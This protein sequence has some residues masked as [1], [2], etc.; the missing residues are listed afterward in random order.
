MDHS[1]TRTLR[2]FRP[3]LEALGDRVVPAGLIG[4]RVFQD[5]TGNGLTPDDAGLA[6]VT[7]RLFADTNRDGVRGAGDLL[8]GSR[9][10]G[11]DGAYAFADL[12]DGRYF[13][14]EAVPSGYVR[15]APALGS[16]A[17]V[18]VLNGASV[19]GQDFNN[20]QRP[21]TD[22]VTGVGYTITRG[23]SSFT[24]TN[25]R[26]QTRQGDAVTAHFTVTDGPPVTVALTTYNA[27]AP[28][29]SAADAWQQTI[30]DEQFGTFGPGRHSL[31]VVIPGNYYQVDF[32]LG[33]AIDRFGPAGSKIFFS[34][35]GRL[36]G[37]DNG[38]TEAPTG[39][40]S[41]RVFV[42]AD[43]SGTFSLGERTLGGVA[44]GLYSS[45]GA[46][47]QTTKTG[48]DGT[49]AF[50]GLV[51]G[52]YTVRETQPADFDDAAD[53][54]GTVAG[55]RVGSNAVNDELSGIVLRA[56][57][58]GVGYNF[59]EAV[60]AGA[61][62]PA[63]LSGQFL[64]QVLVNEELVWQPAVGVKLRLVGADAA[65]QPVSLE[66]VTDPNG[67]FWFVD[68]PAGTYSVEQVDDENGAFDVVDG[69]A[70]SAG[71]ALDAAGDRFTGIVLDDG[72]AA[73]GYLFRA[74]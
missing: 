29:F 1:T 43:G 52:T 70:G 50:G 24:V 8:V 14:V 36:L 64:V 54:V 22:R 74:A 26:G 7:V 62:Q 57:Q 38:G 31:T 28:S 37:A 65:G 68:V 33:R 45:K 53:H 63:A 42:D 32:T 10:S 19:T 15:T 18:D 61:P 34:A 49:Y 69:S 72:E 12:A 41:G 23:G 2:S 6:G 55:V 66:T 59:T 9:V 48:A 71:G 58:S 56:G 17:T 11:A 40:V 3:T 20:Y 67:N 44:V 4:G 5:A 46:L 47:L 39:G 35:Q 25:L 51:A 27:P 73:A 16:H 30:V 13:V 21:A 60:R